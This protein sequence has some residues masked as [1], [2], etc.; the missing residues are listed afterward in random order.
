MDDET[1][2]VL[3]EALTRTGLFNGETLAENASFECIG[4]GTNG[5]V[6]KVLSREGKPLVVKT[7]LGKPAGKRSV[8]EH[9]FFEKLSKKFPES[10]AVQDI[11][12]VSGDSGVIVSEYYGGG[13][14]G[15]LLKNKPK[16]ARELCEDPDNL[17]AMFEVFK[18]IH[19]NNFAHLDIK[20]ENIFVIENEDG[21]CRPVIADFGEMVEGLRGIQETGTLG[22]MPP[23]QH[24]KEK[25]ERKMVDLSK[26]D[27]FAIGL[28]L[29]ESVTGKRLRGIFGIDDGLPFLTL[30]ALKF[31]MSSI[32]E[33][34]REDKEQMIQNE[35]D[36]VP[37]LPPEMKKI[38]IG[39][40]KMDPKERY[41]IGRLL[42]KARKMKENVERRKI[43]EQ[44]EGKLVRKRREDA[45]ESVGEAI[46]KDILARELADS[47]N[48]I[49]AFMGKTATGEAT[50]TI[51]RQ[52]T[53]VEQSTT[54]S[55]RK[56]SGFSLQ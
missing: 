7:Q 24:D 56:K 13:D 29:L 25:G 17:I 40:T 36:K 55:K 49:N 1:R 50:M 44:R 23:E 12:Y 10:S 20:P 52:D 2:K 38:I 46:D 51:V 6:Y 8:G 47:S 43:R 53:E 5:K 32:Y 34:K 3:S 18:T 16:K 48:A 14:L 4:R 33:Y 54:D 39:A 21:L 22:Y 42:E 35:L 27:V 19:D 15:K 9:L 37:S 28:T 11:K 30:K 31:L 26:A 45:K 41:T